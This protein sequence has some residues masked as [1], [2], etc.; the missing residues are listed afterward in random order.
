MIRAVKR[1]V[2][3]P[4]IGNGDVVS[5]AGAVRMKA[6]T[7][8][9]AVMI[10][11]AAEGN[12]WIFRETLCALRGGEYVPPDVETRVKAALTPCPKCASTWRGIWRERRAAA[13]CGQGSIK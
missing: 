12:P 8:C 6:E 2:R 10:A 3:I 5:G 4:V 11:R 7:G 1:A 9:D 13:S